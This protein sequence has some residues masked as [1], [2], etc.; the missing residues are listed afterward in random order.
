MNTKVL[1]KRLDKLEESKKTE[2]KIGIIVPDTEEIPDEKAFQAEYARLKADGC[3]QIIIVDD[4]I[5][6]QP[7]K[8]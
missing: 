8:N 5:P 3:T 6:L 1:K 4:F 2:Y 7:E